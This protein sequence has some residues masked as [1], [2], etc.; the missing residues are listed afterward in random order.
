MSA[1]IYAMP[2]CFSSPDQL[3]SLERETGLTAIVDDKHKVV[4]LVTEEEFFKPCELPP[5][6]TPGTA[7]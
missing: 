6:A 4:R 2:S 1:N 5:A 3:I 7:A